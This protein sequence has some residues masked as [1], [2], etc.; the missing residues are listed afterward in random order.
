VPGEQ[1]LDRRALGAGTAPVDQADLA[2]TP[3]VGRVQVVVD[4]RADVSWRERVEVE[5]ILDGDLDGLVLGHPMP[6]AASGVSR[7]A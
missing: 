1:S 7:Y 2:K 5:R 6:P 4:H 3:R